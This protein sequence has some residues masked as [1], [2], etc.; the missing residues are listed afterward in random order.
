MKIPTIPLRLNVY[1]QPRHHLI[2]AIPN[3]FSGSKNQLDG[4]LSKSQPENN[5][6]NRIT[7]PTTLFTINEKEDEG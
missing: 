4:L 3:S 6:Q 2:Q 5:A 7:S 1:K